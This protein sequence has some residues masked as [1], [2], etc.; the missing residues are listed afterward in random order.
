MSVN[1][2]LILG[3]LLS[4]SITA[5]AHPGASRSVLFDANRSCVGLDPP[6]DGQ[7]SVRFAPGENYSGHWGIDY[8]GGSDGYVR[9]AASGRVT[10][11]GL[12]VGNL[13]V[14]VDHG[15]GLKTSYSYLDGVAVTRGQ[16][17]ARGSVLGR[18]GSV[19]GHGDVHFS[20]RIDGLYIDPESLLGCL[21]RA[22]TAGLRL[23]SVV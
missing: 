13:V 7:V 19:S 18:A 15:G 6:A 23:V 8:R 17:V 21:P 3:I 10:F 16:R 12:V 4:V 20:V 14:T 11:S 2:L 22:P 1:R 9:A 5:P